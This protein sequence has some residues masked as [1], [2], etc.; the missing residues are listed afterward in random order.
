MKSLFKTLIVP[1]IEYCSQLW[2]PT[3]AKGIQNIE[4]LQKDLLNRIPAIRDIDYWDQLKK[5]KMLSLQRRLERYRILYTWKVVEGHVP[6][7]GV[8]LKL[9]IGRTGRKCLIPKLNTR[10]PAS[11]KSM[12]DQTFQVHGPQLFNVLPPEIRNVTGCSIDDFKSKLDKFLERV[13]DEPSVRGLTPGGC[14]SNC[15]SS[16]SLIDQVK[17]TRPAGLRGG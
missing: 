3:D 14:D 13:P 8:D 5:L 16:N 7:C 17:R 10:C 4:K 11:V 9:D 2:M 1:H 15:K 6:N 12:R